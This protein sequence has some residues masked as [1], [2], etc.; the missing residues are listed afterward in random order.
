MLRNSLSNALRFA[1][2]DNTITLDA[3][4]AEGGRTR[5]RVI[6][7]GAGI[8][9]QDLPHVFERLYRGDQGRTRED[10]GSGLGLAI[11]P[12]LVDAHG[13]SIGVES[14]VGR[15]TSFSILL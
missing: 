6:D 12:A 7:T 5:L 2:P 3:T 10:D 15:G 8:P 13:G 1:P 14:Q 9:P 4:P 11:A